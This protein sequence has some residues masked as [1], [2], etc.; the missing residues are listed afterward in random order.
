M[1]YSGDVSHTSELRHA[2][3]RLHSCKAGLSTILHVTE[4]FEGKTAWEGDIHVFTIQGHPDTD[5]C[6]AWSSAVEG[7]DK[8][9][10]YAILKK[11]PV[12]SPQAAVRVALVADYK[13]GRPP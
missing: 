6:Y 1:T 10:F 3:E 8:Q 12:D 7:S 2:V 13:A 11:P 4:S 9:R 5:T